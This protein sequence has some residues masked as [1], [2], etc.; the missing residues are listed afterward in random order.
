MNI[1]FQSVFR[2]VFI[3]IE[4]ATLNNYSEAV[5]ERGCNICG[6]LYISSNH[7]LRIRDRMDTLKVIV[8]KWWIADVLITGREEIKLVLVAFTCLSNYNTPIIFYIEI[9]AC[10]LSSYLFRVDPNTL[11][12]NKNDSIET[13]SKLTSRIH[14]LLVDTL[15]RNSGL[16]RTRCFPKLFKTDICVHWNTGTGLLSHFSN[17]D[18]S[19]D[20]APR[21]LYADLHLCMSIPTNQNVLDHFAFKIKNKSTLEETCLGEAIITLMNGMEQNPTHLD[22]AILTGEQQQHKTFHSRRTRGNNDATIIAN[23]ENDLCWVEA[24]RKEHLLTT[25]W[26]ASKHCRNTSSSVLLREFLSKRARAIMLISNADV[27]LINNDSKTIKSSMG[28]GVF[29]VKRILGG[30]V[31]YQGPELR[32]CDIP[33]YINTQN[34]VFASDYWIEGESSIRLSNA[35]LGFPMYLANASS[36]FANM[37]TRSSSSS[38]SSSSSRVTIANKLSR[39]IVEVP[40]ETNALPTADILPTLSSQTHGYIWC[41]NK[42]TVLKDTVL[43]KYDFS[44]YFPHI[45]LQ[46]PLFKQSDIIEHLLHE[47]N[48]VETPTTDQQIKQTLVAMSGCLSF[49]DKDSFAQLGTMARSKMIQ[50]VTIAEGDGTSTVW[51]IARDGFIVHQPHNTH[52]I[53]EEISE[54]TQIKLKYEGQY[55]DL[56]IHHVN[57]LILFNRHTGKVDM[58]GVQRKTLSEVEKILLRECVEHFCNYFFLE[59]TDLP[60]PSMLTSPSSSFMLRPHKSLR[61]TLLG[62][63][64]D[65]SRHA[66]GTLASCYRDKPYLVKTC[67]KAMPNSHHPLN[68]CNMKEETVRDLEHLSQMERDN[69]FVDCIRFPGHR[70]LDYGWYTLRVLHQLY[71]LRHYSTEWYDNLKECLVQKA[72]RETEENKRHLL[73]PKLLQYS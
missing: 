57:Q 43:R 6:I 30:T 8:T 35:H 65:G 70:V 33:T 66:D 10:G 2:L 56:L 68:F 55:T 47:R 71:F 31:T 27:L 15:A 50:A 60:Q 62:S 23:A 69:G 14:P 22:K 34:Y 11:L 53:E 5:C 16:H 73:F 59:K 48:R 12:W 36:Q 25:V 40:S 49:N 13:L 67:E 37:Y 9:E 17:V 26:D 52:P 54:V 41:R 72:T 1:C 61:Y 7:L 18:G 42:Q 45:L 38:S 44:S 24:M 20:F 39:D 64:R 19:L 28:A 29:F 51:R 3:N 46:I 58:V 4:L 21:V 32:H 63:T